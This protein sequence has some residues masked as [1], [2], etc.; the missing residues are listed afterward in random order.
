MKNKKNQMILFFY[1]FTKYIIKQL[2]DLIKIFLVV[3]KTY[4]FHDYQGIFY[5]D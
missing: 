4:L 3:P 1:N 2:L 5:Y